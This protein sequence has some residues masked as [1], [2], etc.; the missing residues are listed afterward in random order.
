MFEITAD[1]KAANQHLASSQSTSSKTFL[2][3]EGK[4]FSLDDMDVI[5][6]ARLAKKKRG[7]NGKDENKFTYLY[8]CYTKIATHVVGRR[9]NMVEQVSNLQNITARYFLSCL[10]APD[11]FGIENDIIEIKEN[12]P[13]AAN[14]FAGQGIENMMQMAMMAGVMP[15]QMQS[16]ESL[17]S[18]QQFE[19]T[20]MQSDL[21]EAVQET[22]FVLDR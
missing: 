4:L 11:T 18:G 2:F 12:M 19:F 1:P 7:P 13:P 22:Q 5:L 10:T 14:M 21:W 3:N 16:P 17:S 15:H 8:N 6:L 9:K 20:Q